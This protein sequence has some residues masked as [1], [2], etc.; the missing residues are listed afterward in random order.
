V[1]GGTHDSAMALSYDH[2]GAWIA[3]RLKGMPAS[4]NCPA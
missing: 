1:M 2:T 4:G 3:D